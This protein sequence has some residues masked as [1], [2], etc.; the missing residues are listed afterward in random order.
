MTRRTVWGWNSWAVG[1]YEEDGS[2]TRGDDLLDGRRYVF[3]RCGQA[4]EPFECLSREEARRYARYL[5]AW[6]RRWHRLPDADRKAVLS[7]RHHEHHERARL[8]VRVLEEITY[9]RDE[10]GEMV[11]RDADG[12]VV[13]R[14]DET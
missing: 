9:R 4:L 10:D 13:S 2:A 14:W 6:E 3:V 11:M 12:S 8:L 7:D 1:F 5:N